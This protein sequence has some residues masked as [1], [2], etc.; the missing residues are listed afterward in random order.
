MIDTSTSKNKTKLGTPCSKKWDAEWIELVDKCEAALGH[1]CCGAHAPD[2]LPCEV[3]SDHRNGRCRFHGGIVGIGAPEGNTNARI[4]GLYS[5]RLQTCGEHC[6]MWQTCPLAGDDIAKMAAAKR[7]LC[8]YEQTEHDLLSKLE[9]ETEPLRRMLYADQS[10]GNPHPMLPELTSLRENLKTLQ[11][12][13]TRAAGAL[14]TGLTQVTSVI[15]KDYSMDSSKPSAALQAYQILSREHRQTTTLFKKI[16][17]DFGLPKTFGIRKEPIYEIPDD[18]QA[19][20][21]RSS[22]EDKR[23]PF[24]KHLPEALKH[25]LSEEQLDRLR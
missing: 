18:Y 7:P 8:P 15:G 9:E 24:D 25:Y 2:D 4:H 3:I 10:P 19:P 20:F 1:R 5:R 16:I 12:M 23:S 17:K 21:A 6:P 22:S 13:I 11:I 14:K